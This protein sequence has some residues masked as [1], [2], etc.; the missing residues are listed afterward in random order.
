M[1]ERRGDSS[2]GDRNRAGERPSSREVREAESLFL[3][4]KAGVPLFI[5]A[6]CED[7]RQPGDTHIFPFIIPG[8]EDTDVG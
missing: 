4:Q 8:G 1:G 2:E 3:R 5:A 6:I 7:A